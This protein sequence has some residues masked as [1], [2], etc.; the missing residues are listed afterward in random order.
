MCGL[1]I[2]K[3][4]GHPDPITYEPKTELGKR[5]QKNVQW[6]YFNGARYWTGYKQAVPKYD[7]AVL[8]SSFLM[9]EIAAATIFKQ[10]FDNSREAGVQ[11][12][13]QEHRPR[14]RPPHGHLHGRDGARLPGSQGRNQG[15]RHQADPRRL[16][17]PLRR[18][19]RAADGI[20]GPAGRLHRQPARRRGSRP[21]RRLRHPDLRQPSWRT[22]RTR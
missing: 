1:A 4:L 20:L 19:V 12:R 15:R 9:G 6:L 10:M 7:L 8:F 16:P 17:V 2:T 21:R 5:L 11:G 22:G 3:M 14:R 13:L 18:A